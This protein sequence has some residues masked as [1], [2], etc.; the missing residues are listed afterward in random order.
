MPRRSDP[1]PGSV[2]AIAP[3]SSPRTSRGHPGRALLVAAVV[4]HVVRRDLVHALAEAREARVQKLLVD[5][6]LEAEVAAE[7]AVLGRHVGAEQAGLPRAPPELGVDVAARL[8][9]LVVGQDLPLDPRPRGLAEELVLVARPG[10]AGARGTRGGH[11]AD[12]RT[13][14]ALQR[15]PCTDLAVRHR[16]SLRA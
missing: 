2:M 1:A 10:R 4:E 6:A 12:H 5:H 13:A 16:N 9:A 8:P 11:A 14:A 7:A 3:T 15:R